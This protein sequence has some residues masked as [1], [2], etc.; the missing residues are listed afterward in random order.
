MK[1]KKGCRR[2]RK[3]KECF[4]EHLEPTATGQ[5]MVSDGV[6][7][8][9]TFNVGTG[10]T[11]VSDGAGNITTI[12]TGLFNNTIT[13]NGGLTGSTGTFTGALIA[14]GGLTGNV[15]GNL[16]GNVTGNSTS[17]SR[18]LITDTR[19]VNSPP[20]FYA[21][22]T[23]VT[24][25]FKTSSVIGLPGTGFVSLETTSPWKDNSAELPIRQIAYD[26]K[27]SK[28]FRSAMP[29]DAA[30]GPWKL[31]TSM[32]ENDYY[33]FSSVGDAD[34]V[35]TPASSGW[36]IDPNSTNYDPAI[37]GG[38]RKGVAW[39]TLQDDSDTSTLWIDVT[40]PSKLAGTQGRTAYVHYLP[41]STCRYFDIFGLLSNNDKVFIKRVNAYMNVNQSDSKQT[42]FNGISIA[43]VPR[44]DRFTKIRIQGVKGRIFYMG[45]GWGKEIVGS[46]NGM[47]HTDNIYLNDPNNTSS[48]V[49]VSAMLDYLNTTLKTTNTTANKFCIGST[50]LTEDDFKKVKN[51]DFPVLNTRSDLTFNSGG[52]NTYIIHNPHDD[53][54][55]LYVARSSTDNTFSPNW[56]WG[57]GRMNIGDRTFGDNIWVTAGGYL[58]NNAGFSEKN[59]FSSP[60]F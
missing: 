56:E 2:R 43:A 51:N 12:D 6:G 14:N 37:R 39:T 49:T 4:V 36:T 58:H 54:K 52:K 59:G 28:Y 35:F 13:A 18:N 45:T 8:L 32:D 20:S 48:I 55:T 23:G 11:L 15:T 57:R 17:S 5:L 30:W 1:T 25:E 41:W 34:T 46:E 26:G 7:N 40:V 47:I 44:A 3:Q 27:T 33:A 19:S 38:S 60:N 16:T 53:R 22:S 24:N 10:K 29:A 31:E 42:Y 50:C 9:S 21:N